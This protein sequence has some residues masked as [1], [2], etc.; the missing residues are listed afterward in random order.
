MSRSLASRRR[1]TPWIHRWSRPLIGAIAILGILNTGYITFTKLSRSVAICPTDGCERVLESPYA[2]V[3]GLPL[4]LFGLLAYI[5]MA[6]LALSPLLVNKETNK[7]L[8]T[9]L[10]N[11]TWPLL[12]IGAT[13][14]T[15]FSG[16]LMYIMTSQFVA[17]FGMQ[18]VCI[19][20]IASAV[21]ALAMLALVLLG[22]DWDDIGQLG[23]LGV[24]TLMVTLVGTLALYAPISAK[25]AESTPTSNP[26]ASATSSPAQGIS[27]PVV[28][29][30]SKAE[31]ELA[32]HLKSI[33]AK[34]YGAYWCPHCH[35]E[36]EA[37]G[38]EAAEIINYVE[39]DSGGVNPQT[40]LCQQVLEKAKKQSGQEVVGFPTWEINGKYFIGTQTLTDLAKNSG[41]KGPLNFKNG[42]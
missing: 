38:K 1:N 33:G 37:F 12:F 20:C 32:K 34:M 36:K 35:D 21:F 4:S 5:V 10:E 8:R 27:V 41:Y 18:G 7:A 15:V 6:I 11:K 14:M 9:S 24:I 40:E 39:C 42:S 31:I 28:N 3:F 2:N 29:T 13:A 22:R 16:Y 17:K 30:S 23:F 19:F 26:T 25:V